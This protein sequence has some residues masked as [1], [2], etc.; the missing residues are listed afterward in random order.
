MDKID[1]IIELVRLLKEEGIVGGSPTNS[2]AGGHIA[3]TP[4]A[5]PGNPPVFLNKKRHVYLGLGSRK[6][7]M[8]P[9]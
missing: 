4:E 2:L 7:W 6:R 1:R 5:D 9:K 8:K 3:G